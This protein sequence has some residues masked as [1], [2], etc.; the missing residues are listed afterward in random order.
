[1]RMGVAGLLVALL[2]GACS[3]GP[4]VSPAPGDRL[5]VVATTT[6]LADL[7][8]HVGG[9]NVNV[10]SLVPRG[11]EVHTFDPAPADAQ[12]L[13]NADLVVMNGL[14]LDDWLARLAINAG[15]P[16]LPILRLG[17]GLTDVDY[18]ANDDA[19]EGQINPH[20][21]LDVT[22]A[23]EYVDR[24]RLQLIQQDPD[25]QADYDTNA[26]DYQATLAELDD[27]IR[28]QLAT[29]PAD[30]RKLVAFHDA[31]P[32]YARAYGIDI[33]G[34]VVAA[35]GQDPSAGEVAA[36]ID[37]IRSA[38]VKLILAE[39]QFPTRLVQ[40]LAAET[41][42]RVESELYTDTLGDAPVDTYVGMMRWD[43]ER[44]VEGLQ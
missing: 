20:L 40:Q 11:G 32:Y 2:A 12:R 18:I 1:M 41:G 42:A 36:L 29:I 10:S 19:T 21:W 23:Q 38:Q 28:A 25:H 17:E 37:A 22:Y 14:G 27:W 34:V 7:V 16:N 3:V 33:V 26:T 6:V 43:T 13:A 44:I 24:I 39:A 35:P 8:S 31:F 5:N 9:N 30:Q 4:Q 15:R